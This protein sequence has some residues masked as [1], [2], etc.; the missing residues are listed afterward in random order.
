MTKGN[1]HSGIKQALSR[2]REARSRTDNELRNLEALLGDGDSDK[3]IAM[4]MA[5]DRLD[6]AFEAEVKACETAFVGKTQHVE[7]EP[8]IALGV[9]EEAPE[10]VEANARRRRSR[11]VKVRT[12]DS[13]D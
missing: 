9:L 12:R 11:A 6:K 13:D 4:L 3:T 1:K 7:H 2:I 5:S 8:S 10:A